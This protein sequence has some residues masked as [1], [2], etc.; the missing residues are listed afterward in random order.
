M[1]KYMKSDWWW[2]SR[3]V[4]DWDNGFPLWKTFL[5]I[6][7]CSSYQEQNPSPSIEESGIMGSQRIFRRSLRGMGTQHRRQSEAW[8]EDKSTVA[9]EWNCSIRKED[10]WAGVPSCP[11]QHSEFKVSLGYMKICQRAHRREVG[12]EGGKNGEGESREEKVLEERSNY[13]SPSRFS[14]IRHMKRNH[15]QEILMMLNTSLAHWLP[16]ESIYHRCMSLFP[17]SSQCYI[18]LPVCLYC[19][20]PSLITVTPSDS[21]GCPPT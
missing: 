8:C 1:Q 13:R 9:R 18:H 21:E 20:P 6:R 16:Q 19:W 15:Y 4:S 2:I 17:D 7:I 12:R 5:F 10:V 11:Q 14:L 3:W